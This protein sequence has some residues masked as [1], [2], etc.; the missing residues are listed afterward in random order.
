MATC[1]VAASCARFRTR[2]VMASSFCRASRNSLFNANSARVFKELRLVDV[3]ISEKL[4]QGSMFR[5]LLA[6]TIFGLG[7]VELR[8]M[9]RIFL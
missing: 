3:Q 2:S 9:S 6:Q 1:M 8:M 5:I 4:H 7:R